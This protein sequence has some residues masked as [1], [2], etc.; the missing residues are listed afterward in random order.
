M[1]KLASSEDDRLEEVL[2]Q[3]RKRVGRKKY[4]MAEMNERYLDVAPVGGPV[5]VRVMLSLAET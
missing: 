5:Q 4:S 2:V 1:V 3:M